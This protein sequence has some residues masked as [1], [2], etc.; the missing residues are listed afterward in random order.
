MVREGKSGYF[1]GNCS[2]Q[3]SCEIPS[4]KL[5]TTDIKWIFML[6]LSA[7]AY[8]E[9]YMQNLREGWWALALPSVGQLSGVAW[10]QL[11]GE[12]ADPELSYSLQHRESED[13]G[14]QTG[15]HQTYIASSPFG[16]DMHIYHWRPFYQLFK[17]LTTA[18]S[19]VTW[20]PSEGWR[21]VLGFFEGIVRLQ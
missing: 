17:P 12:A 15:N 7:F 6:S 20:C 21:A 1:S 14:L 2:L 10:I 11:W 3:F 5:V 18:R 9:K 13:M 19:L 8:G 16:F 4:T